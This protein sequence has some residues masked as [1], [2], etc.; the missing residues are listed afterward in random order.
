MFDLHTFESSFQGPQPGI[1]GGERVP[2]KGYFNFGE[3]G[4]WTG[5]QDGHYIDGYVR[6]FGNGNF[7]YPIG[8]EGKFRPAAVSTGTYVEAAYYGVNPT[9]SITSDIRGGDFPVLPGT[10]PFDSA[11]K[12]PTLVR[13]STYEY[14]DINGPDPAYITLT[15]DPDSHI[16]SITSNALNTLTIVGWNGTEW[17]AIPS[18]L[19]TNAIDQTS[20]KIE[21]TGP[22]SYLYEGSITTSVPIIPSDY[23]VYTFGA[24]CD[25]IY[26]QISNDTTIC[27]GASVL[28]N[29]S[30]FDDAEI[31]WNTGVTGNELYI[32]PGVSTIYTA[33]A[34]LGDCVASASVFVEVN[35]PSVDL[36]DDIFICSG[37]SVTIHAYTQIG[38]E[39][40]WSNNTFGGDEITVTPTV[41]TSYSVTVVDSYGC[42]AADTIDVEV[43]IKPD[44]FTG[45]ERS[46][47]LGDSVFIQAFGSTTGYGYMWSTGDTTDIITVSPTENTTYEVY[48]TENGCTDTSSVDVMLLI[49][50]EV[51]ITGDTIICPGETI[52]LTAFGPGDMYTWSTGDNTNTITIAPANPGT[53]SVTMTSDELCDATDEIYID[54]YDESFIQLNDNI[55]T[56]PGEMATFE[57]SG[58]YDSL[59]WSDGSTGNTLNVAPMETTSYSVTTFYRSCS[60]VH[61]LLVTVVEDLAF[62]LG[63]DA[64]IC[65]GESITFNLDSISGV[66]NW[67]TGDTTSS[68]T[69]SPLINTNY[70]VTITSGSCVVSDSININ[71]Q[72]DNCPLDLYVLKSVNEL[73]PDYGDVVTF[74]IEIGNNSELFATNVELSDVLPSGFNYLSYSSSQGVYNEI[75]GIWEVGTLTAFQDAFLYMDVEVLSQGIHTNTAELFD[76]DQQDIDP[77]NNQ[78][79]VTLDP[80]AS[81]AIG[82]LIWYDINGNGIQDNNETGIEGI[83]VELYELQNNGIPID[84]IY[85]NA[86]GEYYFTELEDGDYYVKV[87]VPD[88]F[89]TTIPMVLQQLGD[90]PSDLDSDIDNSIEP[91]STGIISI[92]NGS[93]R[94]DCDGGLHKYSAIGNLVWIENEDVSST[95]NVYDEDI[96]FMAD[97]ILIELFDENDNSIETQST[98]DGL[99]LFDKLSPG[100]YYLKISG[101]PDSTALVDPFIGTVQTDSDYVPLNPNVGSVG[102]T[103]I[104]TL[105]VEEI[106]MDIDAGLEASTNVPIELYDFWGERV[107]DEQFNRLFWIT[108]TEVNTDYFIIER[109]IDQIHSFEEIGDVTAAGNSSAREYYTFDDLD[110]RSQGVYYYRLISVDLNGSIQESNI[111]S[112]EV[113]EEESSKSIEYKVYPIPSSDYVTLEINS[114]VEQEFL[115]YLV[116]N[117]G[118]N[119]RKLNKRI[120]PSGLTEIEFD[121]FDLA[122]GQYYLNFYLDD[123]QHITKILVM[124]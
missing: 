120:L 50:S 90:P 74:T 59:I 108:E 81:G 39:Y 25:D 64:S 76:L 24:T 102:F 28:L 14:W 69:V 60:I 86:A 112:I 12:D 52:D 95:P 115:G 10:G 31:E 73:M 87:I 78:D 26:V 48:L 103:K 47:C 17:E 83:G 65:N 93:E 54:I 45:R 46:V 72:T 43:G 61:P 20:E 36:G 106:N 63:P 38:M 33:T 89:M 9:N 94:I 104:I 67:S 99:Y 4:G 114:P 101:L 92:V 123:E 77:M 98:V 66:F 75:T 119:V 121:V 18:Q 82:N 32:F 30:S 100:D 122:Q 3:D 79:S 107:F 84:I 91:G 51:E 70:S 27:T 15:W 116:N 62:E 55:F 113:L 41:S 97:G 49:P 124:N 21:F 2:E 22:L 105:G 8:D 7:Q 68:I 5:A 96:D 11:L 57:I 53:Y 23:E 16:D 37:E 13:V 6:Y 85:T 40:Y 71:L 110:S 111:I 44:V 1:I 118:Q 29:A 109:A 117:M 34:Q 56:C 35:D 19:N 42:S 80:Q 58:I 88:S